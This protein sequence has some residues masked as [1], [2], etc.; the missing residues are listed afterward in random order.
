MARV[1]REVRAEDV[2]WLAARE[3]GLP[4]L[5]DIRAALER[6]PYSFAHVAPGYLSDIMNGKRP[7]PKGD[8]G[9]ALLHLLGLTL[10]DVG[11]TPTPGNG[12]LSV[13]ATLKWTERNPWP[14]VAGGP[15]PDDNPRP[16]RARAEQQ[17]HSSTT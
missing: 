3:R 4:K 14:H 16:R 1:M 12:Y 11:I 15:A 2:L 13:W 6:A 5:T 8:L 7:L 10:A 9:A 17:E